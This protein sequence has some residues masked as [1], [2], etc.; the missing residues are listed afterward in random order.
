LT[1]TVFALYY[2]VVKRRHKLLQLDNNFDVNTAIRSLTSGKLVWVTQK[3]KGRITGLYGLRNRA[4]G[5]E[6]FFPA[7]KSR[8]AHHLHGQLHPTQMWRCFITDESED[9]SYPLKK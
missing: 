3:G 7:Y 1:N 8:P 2:K 4:I 5:F 6:A 9:P